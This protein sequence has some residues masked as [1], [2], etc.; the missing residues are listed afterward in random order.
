MD[1]SFEKI[2]LGG[3]IES[4]VYAYKTGIPIILVDPQPPFVFD[5]LDP[6]ISFKELGI[7]DNIA[8]KSNSGEVVFGP[9]KLRIWQKLLFLLSLSGK[10]IYGDTT[11]SVRIEENTLYVSL[12]RVK[13]KKV[14]FGSLVVFSDE[15]VIGLDSFKKKVI[16]KSIVYDWVN[17]KSG[18]THE[19]DIFLF[20]DDFVRD[21]YFYPSKRNRNTKQKDLVAVSYLTDEELIDFSYSDTYV[22][23]KLLQDFKD[24]GIRGAR[25]G[26]DPRNPE[27]YKYYAVKL[28]PANRVVKKR[29]FNLYENTDKIIFN[30]QPLEELIEMEREES[31]YLTRISKII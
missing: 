13:N 30:Y 19:Y 21:V 14:E 25:N 23:F 5:Y 3:S 12:D 4:L 8:L 24:L 10:V 28:E 9:N 1:L 27:K 18:G 2:I 11:R 15:N 6:E 22:K 16:K 26:R 31:G 7:D 20:D 17:I 29:S